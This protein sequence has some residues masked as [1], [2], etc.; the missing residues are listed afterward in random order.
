MLLHQA[1]VRLFDGFKARPRLKSEHGKGCITTTG[2]LEL[3]LGPVRTSLIC[4]GT[5]TLA[6]ALLTGITTKVLTLP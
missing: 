3:G 4:T 2:L 6:V 5:A 1:A